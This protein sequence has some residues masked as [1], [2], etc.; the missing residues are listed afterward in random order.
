MRS[1]VLQDTGWGPN[2]G[3]RIA[4]AAA[5]LVVLGLIGLAIYGGTIRPTQV[6]VEKVLPDE[7]FAR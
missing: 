3:L 7:R 4:I 5:V 6:S 2:W 1:M